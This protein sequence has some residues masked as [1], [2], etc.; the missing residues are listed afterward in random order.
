MGLFDGKVVLITGAS[1]GIGAETAIQFAEDGAS[2]ALVGRNEERLE[3]TAKECFGKGLSKD[4]V[5]TIK[6]DVCEEEDVKRIMDVTIH[7][8]GKLDVLVNNAGGGAPCDLLN[9]DLMKT[10]DWVMKLNVRSVLQLS[11]LAVPHLI[12]TKGAI[13]NVSSVCGKRVMA[14]MTVYNM[15][16]ATIDQFT[17]VTA[18]ELAPKGVRV[19]AVNPGTIMTPIQFAYGMN[20]EQIRER[21]K[22]VHPLGRPGESN[23]VAPVIKFL[24]S[25]A[26][27]FITGETLS[28]DGGRH[29][30][31]AR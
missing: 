16:K 1:S 3:N 12:A 28:I 2:L 24:A 17:R 4:K 23:E 30:L 21:A 31:C 27:S 19:N 22:K 11:N 7:H 10:F 15:A 29:V 13:V 26:A 9:E 6:A 18:V 8:F 14:N 5:L 20:D 25:D